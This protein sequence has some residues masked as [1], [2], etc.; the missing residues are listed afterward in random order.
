MLNGGSATQGVPGSI[1][2]MQG[3]FEQT[4]H[5]VQGDKLC[6]KRKSYYNKQLA[7]GA[8]TQWQKQVRR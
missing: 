3:A 5:Y 8:T 6:Y 4:F 1:C 7:K 2:A